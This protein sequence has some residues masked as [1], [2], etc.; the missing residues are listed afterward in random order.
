MALSGA[1][2]AFGHFLLNVISNVVVSVLIVLLIVKTIAPDLLTSAFKAGWDKQLE[3]LKSE[4]QTVLERFK[5][6][7]SV[8]A[9]IIAD[10]Y[11]RLIEAWWAWESSTYAILLTSDPRSVD[12]SEAIV[13]TRRF[14]EISYRSR[15]YLTRNAIELTSLALEALDGPRGLAGLDN[16]T[17]PHV[18]DAAFFK[19]FQTMDSALTN[20]QVSLEAEFRKILKAEDMA[21]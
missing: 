16:R 20:L 17:Q 5:T 8:R 19:Q 2:T 11:A 13:A 14:R 15:L 10:L 3:Q 9:D 6:L 7:H 18:T 12:L 1:L 21:S 4:L